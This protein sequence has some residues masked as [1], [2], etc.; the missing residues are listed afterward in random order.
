MTG[1]DAKTLFVIAGQSN[2]E[3]NVKLDGLQKMISALPRE[4]DGS[5]LSK[6]DRD[7]ARQ[8][9]ADSQGMMCKSDVSTV[10]AADKTID[11]L[12]ASKVDWRSFTPS[13]QHPTVQ[14]LAAQYSHAKVTLHENKNTSSDVEG[15]GV[16]NSEYCSKLCSE[17]MGS[18]SNTHGARGCL[19]SSCGSNQFLSCS[20]ACI[21]KREG[22]S[23]SKCLSICTGP[24]SCEFEFDTQV[25]K[26]CSGCGGC[27]VPSTQGCEHA[28]VHTTGTSGL[29]EDI[30][31]GKLVDNKDCN[32]EKAETTRHGPKLNRY[33]GTS[34]E[35]LG[36]GFGAQSQDLTFG[37]ELSFGAEIGK[38]FPDAM[39]LKVAMGG[40]SLG[41]HWRADGP[42]Y[43]QL[44]QET[45]D[46]LE[47]YQADFG[48][49]VWFQG[50]NDQFRDVWCDELSSVYESR[51][52]AFLIGFRSDMEIDVPVVIV[53]ARS[54]YKLPVIQQAQDA[55][56]SA[57]SNVSVVPSADLS[58]CFHYDSGSQVV[59]GERAATAMLH[60]LDSGTPP[61][62]LQT[63]S[64]TTT[65]AP[66]PKRRNCRKVCKKANNPKK[67]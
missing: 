2:A 62:S 67:V 28:C 51:L 64:T 48:G 23:E 37:P 60:I 59:I 55:V 17:W 1:V 33:T 10:S 27:N 63:T 16:L 21:A 13:Y 22:A 58:E 53:K 29:P 66:K 4:K 20:Q 15:D 42:L 12:R 49:F 26:A 3:G 19:D 32:A 50:F 35:P 38:R 36:A 34:F 56:A 9:V 7:I 8:A 24:R 6:A 46:A 61:Q 14:I 57:L 31:P 44:V 18:A 43:A 45:K 39:L 40:S 54:S 30:I 65:E 47:Q 41:D 52:K 25:F 5:K 11:E